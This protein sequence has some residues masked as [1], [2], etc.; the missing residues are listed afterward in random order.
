MKWQK[1]IEKMHNIEIH[2]SYSL[3]SII[4]TIKSS[5]VTWGDHVAQMEKRHTYDVSGKAGRKETPKRTN[6]WMHA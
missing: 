4:R 2:N 1:G 5:R 6:I 3:S